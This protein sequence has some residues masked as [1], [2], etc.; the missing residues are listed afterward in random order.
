M[1][2][3]HFMIITLI[4]QNDGKEI[5]WGHLWRL[6][7]DSRT[8]TGLCYIPKLKF[9]HICLNSF[10]KMRVDLAAQV[11]YKGVDK[12]GGGQGASAPPLF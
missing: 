4:Q 11:R 5:K 1:P 10:S 7:Y 6:Y 8:P 9:E 3:C 2:T 12:G